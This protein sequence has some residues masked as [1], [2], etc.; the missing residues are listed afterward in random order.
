MSSFR[1]WAYMKRGYSTYLMFLVSGINVTLITHRLLIE[2][3]PMLSGITLLYYAL[4]IVPIGFLTAIII[5]WWDYKRGSFHA[6]MDTWMTEN[7][8]MK[9]MYDNI[10]ELKEAKKK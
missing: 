8:M 3:I 1:Y 10:K 9:E 2:R 5:G 6:E 7:K 4:I